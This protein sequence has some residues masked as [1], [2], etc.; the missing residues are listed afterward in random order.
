[1]KLLEER[2]KLKNVGTKV[3]VD[4]IRSSI[5]ILLNLKM[6]DNN[7]LNQSSKGDISLSSQQTSKIFHMSKIIIWRFVEK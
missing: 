7:P 2:I 4:Y 1:M 6:E 5:E 3:I